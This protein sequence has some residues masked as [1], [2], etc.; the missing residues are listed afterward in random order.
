M[1]EDYVKHMINQQKSGSH[2]P[3]YDDLGITKDINAIRESA[4][5]TYK[6]NTGFDNAMHNP[7]VVKKV[8]DT[9]KEK[10]GYD[11][12]MHNPECYCTFRENNPM[13]DKDI[14]EARKQDCLEKT[15][16]E[17]YV[18]TEE[19]KEKAKETLIETTGVDNAMKNKKI[20]KTRENNCL[21]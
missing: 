14:L 11:H 2:S 6:Q 7:K 18:Q 5:A 20:L 1:L 12:P 9:Y 4:S 13:K 21:N 16:K 19:F 10:T 8:K 3:M 17:W 15:G